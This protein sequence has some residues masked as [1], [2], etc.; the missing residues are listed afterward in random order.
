ML[1]G[2]ALFVALGGT[3]AAAT[4]SLVNI[5]DPSNSADIAHVDSSGR[6]QV[7]DSAGP[8]T[9]KGSGGT[10][11]ISG[12]VNPT[13][14]KILAS[15]SCSANSGADPVTVTVP[16]TSSLRILSIHLS[17]ITEGENQAQLMMTVPG[18]T[19]PVITLMV[20]STSGVETFVPDQSMYFASGLT[21]SASGNWTFTCSDLNSTTSGGFGTW[22]VL[23][24]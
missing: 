21:S 24:T 12:A 17:G 8:L 9:V 15:G 22:M 16:N 10:I 20:N 14:E 11:G 18:G 23:G 19:S 7:G 4:G 2:L 1:G 3:A 6:L 5:A 13:P